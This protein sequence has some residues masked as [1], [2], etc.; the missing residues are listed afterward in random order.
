MMQ[1]EQE[2]VV[3]SFRDGKRVSPRYQVSFETAQD[4]QHYHGQRA[5]DMLV[6]IAKGDLDSGI[7]K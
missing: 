6:E 2:L 5:T 1:T 4:F 7:V 3:A